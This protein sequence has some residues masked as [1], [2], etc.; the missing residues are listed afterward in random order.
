MADRGAFL[1]QI[2]AGK[3]LKKTQ[4]NEQSAVPV[5]RVTGGG[6]PASGMAPPRPPVP[7]PGGF[8]SSSISSAPAEPRAA[9]PPGMPSL[10]GL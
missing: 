8:S 2:Q 1:Q 9:P 7:P 4:T 10:G 6:P 3:R 5:G